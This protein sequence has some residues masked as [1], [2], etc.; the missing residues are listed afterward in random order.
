LGIKFGTNL[1]VV[2]PTF[3]MN[4]STVPLSSSAIKWIIFN[5]EWGIILNR[6]DSPK[7]KT[8]LTC[9]CADKSKSN[10]EQVTYSV[11]HYSVIYALMNHLYESYYMTLPATL[12]RNNQ[13][14]RIQKGWYRNH[15]FFE[16]LTVSIKL[17]AWNERASNCNRNQPDLLSIQ[18][19]VR[20]TRVHAS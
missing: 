11:I 15:S 7:T 16:L 10:H 17:F 20:P 5:F 1:G 18:Q 2:I 4:G 13:A 9:S 6:S 12:N 14:K 8:I 19:L 3:C